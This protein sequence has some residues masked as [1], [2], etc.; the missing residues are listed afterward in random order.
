MVWEQKQKRTDSFQ[1]GD[2]GNLKLLEV[3]GQQFLKRI[4]K[5]FFRLVDRRLEDLRLVA[6]Y[7]QFLK[8]IQTHLGGETQVHQKFV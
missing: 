2:P 8:Q 6:A 1:I 4:L 3:V 5:V 7:R